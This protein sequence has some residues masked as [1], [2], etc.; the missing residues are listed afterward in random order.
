MLVI[1]CSEFIDVSAKGRNDIHIY[2]YGKKKKI[3]DI[4]ICYCFLNIKRILL[5]PL[6]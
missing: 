1:G 5:K 6:H 3:K 4:K 2:I